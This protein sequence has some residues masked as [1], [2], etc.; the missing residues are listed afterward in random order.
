[1]G[2]S[3]DG[4]G[5]SEDGVGHSKGGVG[6]SEGGEFLSGRRVIVRSNPKRL[7]IY[8]FLLWACMYVICDYEGKN[9]HA[10]MF[11]FIPDPVTN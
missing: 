10:V 7:D 6:T 1:M 4:V 11:S 8:N 5:T 9:V 3:E 2:T